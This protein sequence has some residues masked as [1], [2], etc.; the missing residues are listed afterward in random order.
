MLLTRTV[1][2]AGEIFQ[3]FWEPVLFDERRAAKAVWNTL[4]DELKA[5][6][7]VLGRHSAGCAA[8]YGVYEACNFKCTACYLSETANETPPLPFAEVREQL[9][10]IRAYL[11]PWGNTQITAG[12]VTLLPCDDLIQILKYCGEIELS[13]MVMTH[14]QTILKDPEYLHRLMREGGLQKISIHIDT[15]QKGRLGLR[16]RDS[17][18]DIHWIRDAFA[19]LVRQARQKTGL[20]LDAATTMTVNARNFDEVPDVIRWCM[21]NTDAFRMIS[22]QPTADVGRTRDTNQGGKRA[23]L[24]SKICEGAGV[25]L[26]Q[27]MFKF[28]HPDCNTTTMMFVVEFH[29]GIELERHVVEVVRPNEEEDRTFFN[30]LIN[31][32]FAGF[33]P[34]G[35]KA[36]ILIARIL[37]RIRQN[38]KFAFSIPAFCLSRAWRERSWLPRLLSAVSAGR[39]W[40]INP[41]VII[42]HNFMNR[43][44]L[45]TEVGQQR[46][47]ACAFR[48]PI[49][50]RMEPMCG[51]NGTDLRKFLNE[52][53]RNRLIS[54]EE[55]DE[56]RIA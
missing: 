9:D 48:V 5:S 54:I 10:Q 40:Q 12:E 8:T 13:A 36:S 51:L 44:E 37:G 41:F 50:G 33:S 49:E 1:R 30:S 38:P 34:D 35:E 20:S 56:R 21:A 45:E 23:E 26:N 47:A 53:D 55:S 6:D 2:K 25:Q 29:N 7:Q 39:P 18:S 42:V 52:R 11:G 19:N 22:F 4:P 27:H 3:A 46:L 32:G 14:G 15:T 24:W 31:D 28:G 16:P 17:E 43:D